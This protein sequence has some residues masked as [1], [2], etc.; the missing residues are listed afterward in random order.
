MFIDRPK[1]SGTVKNSNLYLRWKKNLFSLKLK[2]NLI[3]SVDG[4]IKK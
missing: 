4:N 3:S 2:L 1:E